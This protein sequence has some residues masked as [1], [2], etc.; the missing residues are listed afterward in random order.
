MHTDTLIIGGGLAGVYLASRLTELGQSFILTEARDRL[1]GRIA[2]VQYAGGTFDMGPAWFWPGQPRIAKVIS[3]LELTRFDQF[4]LGDLMY[5]DEKGCPQR[6][7]G[8]SSMQG[9]YRL[10]GGLIRLIDALSAKIDASNLQL[11]API[12]ALTRADGFITATYRDGRTVTASRVVMAIPPRLAAQI[13]FT[14]ALP[15]HALQTMQN[16][17]TWMAGHA[18]A[19]AIYDRPFWRD[20]GLSGDAMS[21]FGPM[22]EIHD[23]SPS[24]GGPFALFGFLG[25]PPQARADQKLLRQQIIAQLTRIFGTNAGAPLQLTIKDWAYD[26]FTA[27]ALDQQPLYAH[28]HYGLPAPLRGL[29]RDT[30][31]F[32]GTEVAQEFGGYLE[33]ALEAAENA[34]DQLIRPQK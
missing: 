32:G 9:S 34:L 14:P 13:S 26:P 18:K 22:A 19:V 30:L 8:F 1:G 17:P 29:W 23:A 15:D 16:I 25:V 12:T 6:G 28:P 2:A 31:L 10:D 4:A 27:T 20:A 3:D 11:S 33:G 21:R 24:Q 5:E 7:Q